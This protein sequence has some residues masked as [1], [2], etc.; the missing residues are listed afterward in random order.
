VCN[1][2]CVDIHKFCPKGCCLV[3]CLLL[4]V[5]IAGAF[6]VGFHAGVWEGREGYGE[7]DGRGGHEKMMRYYDGAGNDWDSA[8]YGD[9]DMNVMYRVMNEP[10]AAPAVPA[11]PSSVAPL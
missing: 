2:T 3:K 7:G 8:A 5:I 9:R 11:T 4:A 10:S 6:A 1:H